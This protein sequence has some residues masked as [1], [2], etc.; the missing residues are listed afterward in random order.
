MSSLPDPA[1][2]RG[3]RPPAELPDRVKVIVVFGGQS[4]EHDVSCVSAANVMAALDRER[5]EIVPI[6][7]GRDGTWMLAGGSTEL[8]P[9][10]TSGP[11]LGGLPTSGPPIDVIPELRSVDA[12][13]APVVVLPV[14]LSLIHI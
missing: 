2:R 9:G 4:A 11:G 13:D 1:S 3:S 5:Y 8:G 7:I 14:L 6:G 10:P 12:G